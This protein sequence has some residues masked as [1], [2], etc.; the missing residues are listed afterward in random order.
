MDEIPSAS[1]SIS[2]SSGD[3]NNTENVV[4][5][6]FSSGNATLQPYFSQENEGKLLQLS[7]QLPCCTTKEIAADSANKIVF[8][9]DGLFVPW[10]L[11]QYMKFDLLQPLAKLQTL[12]NISLYNSIRI[13]LRRRGKNGGLKMLDIARELAIPGYFRE[14]RALWNNYSDTKENDFEFAFIRIISF[15]YWANANIYPL[16]DLGP[17][18]VE[19]LML[20]YNCRWGETSTARKYFDI[21]MRQILFEMKDLSALRSWCGILREKT[22]VDVA[23]I[24]AEYLIVLDLGTMVPK[25]PLKKWNLKELFLKLRNLED[26]TWLNCDVCTLVYLGSVNSLKR[27][28]LHITKYE[29]V[30]FE[31]FF[32]RFGLDIDTDLRKSES[33]EKVRQ[34]VHPLAPQS[35]IH[36]DHNNSNSFCSTSAS[37]Y[38]TQKTPPL[39]AFLGQSGFTDLNQKEKIGSQTWISAEPPT[40]KVYLDYAALSLASAILQCEEYHLQNQI[41]KDT[42][43]QMS[44]SRIFRIPLAVITANTVILNLPPS[45]YQSCLLDLGISKK[46]FGFGLPKEICANIKPNRIS[47][48][49]VVQILEDS[50]SNRRMR[51][52]TVEEAE[53][54]VMLDYYRKERVIHLFNLAMMTFSPKILRLHFTAAGTNMKKYYKYR[55]RSTSDT[56]VLFLRYVTVFE[57]TLDCLTFQIPHVVSYSLTPHLE[58]VYITLCGLP[59]NECGTIQNVMELFR[60]FIQPKEHLRTVIFRVNAPQVSMLFCLMIS[61]EE[62]SDPLS[63]IPETKILKQLSSSICDAIENVHP[64]LRKQLKKLI[65]D[66][67]V[68]G[69][70]SAEHVTYIHD[71]LPN[72][73]F[74]AELAPDDCKDLK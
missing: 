73:T 19:K 22:L 44:R 29:H 60:F 31:Q 59:H 12:R 65:L 1:S 56:S 2:N 57:L 46:K 23:M 24:R 51:G 48:G 61:V 5:N 26:F 72:C 13:E 35:S 27:L 64:I 14:L 4:L 34:N 16:T 45:L 67:R 40:K 43:F 41:I 36:D 37:Q 62:L 38:R 6:Q 18:N 70:L 21:F 9:P 49:S 11:Y 15:L 7:N 25:G 33:N 32:A 28:V 39:F 54:H 8:D 10:E 69:A 47:Y 66:G 50:A 30:F 58:E 74:G 42:E 71:L 17:L 53:I 63:P 55:P 20:C 68:W 3:K 52:T